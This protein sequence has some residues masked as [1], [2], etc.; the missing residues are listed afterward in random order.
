MRKIAAMASVACGLLWSSFHAF[1]EEGWPMYGRNLPH[2]FT[3]EHSLI[4]PSSVLSLKPAWDFATE[5][6]VTASPSVVGGIV[7]VGA[8]DG[9]FY[10]LNAHS[11][12]LI[13]KFAVDCQ[14]TIVPIPARCPQPA[15]MP[16][17]FLS[18]GGL[19][20]SCVIRSRNRANSVPER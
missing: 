18:D 9:Y 19:I 8:W 16:P 17:R 13:W 2:T 20:T 10:A 1:A 11:G 5:D 15:Q 3:N 4:N 6:V 14:S 12:T 7:Y